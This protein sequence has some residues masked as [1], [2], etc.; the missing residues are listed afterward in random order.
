VPHPTPPPPAV[1]G[2]L[3]MISATDEMWLKNAVQILGEVC[4]RHPTVKKKLSGEKGLLSDRYTEPLMT[5]AS[6]MIGKL[7]QTKQKARLSLAGP[8]AR[9]SCLGV[10]DPLYLGLAQM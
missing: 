4:A 6:L 1:A 7:M 5:R 8:F 3:R 2:H 9:L 10:V